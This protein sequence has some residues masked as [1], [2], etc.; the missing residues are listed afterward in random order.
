MS[1]AYPNAAAFVGTWF[2]LAVWQTVR[3]FN[4]CQTA[5]GWTDLFWVLLVLCLAAPLF[6][7]ARFKRYPAGVQERQTADVTLAI[8][9]LTYVPIMLSMRLLEQCVAA[10]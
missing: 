9:V 10:R 4:R 1:L 8:V 7:V 3:A 5:S 6:V 2:V